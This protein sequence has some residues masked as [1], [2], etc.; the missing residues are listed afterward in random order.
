MKAARASRRFPIQGGASVSWD[1]AIK[2]YA[3]YT[4]RY[5]HCSSLERLADRG[6]LSAIQYAE[7]RFRAS[8]GP[9]ENEAVARLIDHYEREREDLRSLLQALRRGSCWCE[10]GVGNPSAS[11]HSDACDRARA[12]LGV[13]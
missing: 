12:V 11:S 5:G 2:A 4:A 13:L 6:G 8:Q 1:D 9:N 3:E 10:V 7:L